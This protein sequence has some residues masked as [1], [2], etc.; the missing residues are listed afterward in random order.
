MDDVETELGRDLALQLFDLFRAEFGDQAGVEVDDVV[1]MRGVG[2]LVPRAAVFEGEAEDNAFAFEDREGAVDG[3][4]R[5]A[6]IEG[7]GA[8]VKLGGV[9][10]VLEASVRTLSRASRWRVTRTPVSRRAWSGAE[11]GVG[12]HGGMVTAGGGGVKPLAGPRWVD[13]WG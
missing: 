12:F 7:P 5:E 3:G 1:V 4:Q 10:V 13:W 11:G 2:D 6:V 9:G 8:A